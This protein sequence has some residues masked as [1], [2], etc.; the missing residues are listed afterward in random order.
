MQDAGGRW[1]ILADGRTP[2]PIFAPDFR[3]NRS[4]Y[5]L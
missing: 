2:R 1:G 5:G 4:P 3:L